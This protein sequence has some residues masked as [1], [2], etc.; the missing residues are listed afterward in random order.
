M[1]NTEVS[2]VAK[3]ASSPRRDRGFYHDTDDRRL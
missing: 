2:G 3:G 1:K